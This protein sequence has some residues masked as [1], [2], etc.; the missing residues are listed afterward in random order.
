MS[1]P[2]IMVGHDAI[3]L[4]MWKLSNV[5]PIFKKKGDEQLTNN[6]RPIFLLPTCG[7]IF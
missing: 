4:E 3:Y 2:G 6:Y 5:T 1:E 7:K